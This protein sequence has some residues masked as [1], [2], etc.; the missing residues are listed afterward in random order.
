MYGANS[1]TGQVLGASAPIANSSV[2]LWAPRAIP[3]GRR[4]AG[5]D[6]SLE[7]QR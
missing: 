7:R 6:L 3:S 4:S 2:T 1:I 5:S